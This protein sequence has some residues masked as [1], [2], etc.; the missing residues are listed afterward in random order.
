M[1]FIVIMIR[2]VEEPAT[3]RKFGGDYLRYRHRVPMF[4]FRPA[5]LK[6]VFGRHSETRW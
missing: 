3:I 6:R 2:L 1:L 5:C 4:S